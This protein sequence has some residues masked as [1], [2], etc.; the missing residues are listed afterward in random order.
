MVEDDYYLDWAESGV[1][2]LLNPLSTPLSRLAADVAART[3]RS[4]CDAALLLAEAELLYELIVERHFGVATGRIP[5][6][7]VRASIM[8]WAGVLES[9]S[10]A[11]WGE[12]VT[13]LRDRLRDVLVDQ[14]L[15][16][17]GAIPQ[18]R[19]SLPPLDGDD[20][21][22]VEE[23]RVGDVLVLRIRRLIGAPSDEALLRS[24]AADSDRH[25]DSARI[26]VDLRGNRGG[27]DGHTLDWARRR[28]GRIEHFARDWTWTVGGKALGNWNAAAWRQARD[29]V[30]SVPPRLLDGRHHPAPSDRLEIDADEAGTIASGD[31]M[32]SGRMV[33]LVDPETKSSGESSAWLLKRGLGATLVGARTCG[34]IEYGNIVPY[35]MPRSGLVIDLP[36][37]RNDFGI[38]V[39]TVGFPVDVEL[40][41]RSR[42]ED[43]AASF[44]ALYRTGA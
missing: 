8:E 19:R 24:W 17:R 9:Q 5:A 22:A 31:L 3:P 37:K 14:H 29:G 13:A 12:A 7:L 26:I 32:W 11:T 40:D 41:P 34:M 18:T 16:I 1:R 10:P 30:K 15:E 36:T 20:G 25:F 6:D 28:L 42:I 23:R 35:V 44:D 43:V 2:W 21:P 33:V 27:N 4:A 39:E 38:P